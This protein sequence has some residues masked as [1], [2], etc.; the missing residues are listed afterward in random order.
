MFVAK[1]PVIFLVKLLDMDH[2]L[3]MCYCK[4][5]ALMLR[6]KKERRIARWI[7]IKILFMTVKKVFVREG[8]SADGHVTIEKFKGS[9]K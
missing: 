5:N 4:C 8:I 1:S 3:S 2:L 6:L 7:D 9:S